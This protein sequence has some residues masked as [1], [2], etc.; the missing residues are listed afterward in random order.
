MFD[1]YLIVVQTTNFVKLHGKSEKYAMVVTWAKFFSQNKMIKL[2][3][4]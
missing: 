3:R 4:P 2:L 1:M